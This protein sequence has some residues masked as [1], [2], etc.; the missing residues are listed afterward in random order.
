M[1]MTAAQNALP[2]ADEKEKGRVALKAF[3]NIT[4]RWECTAQEQAKLLGDVARST[5]YGYRRQPHRRLDRDTL[6]RISAIM[7]IYKAL[8]ILYPNPEIADSRPRRET[9]DLPFNGD[10]PLAFMLRGSLLHLIETRR[11]FDA[12]RGW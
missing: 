2:S 5:L 6:E 7:G 1:A 8:H 11:Y 4:E 9:S 10:S 12:Q 3:F